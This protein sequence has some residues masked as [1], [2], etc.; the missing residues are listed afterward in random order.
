[1]IKVELSKSVSYVLLET[2]LQLMKDWCRKSFGPGVCRT[3]T[4]VKFVW[5]GGVSTNWD[6]NLNYVVEFSIIFYFK[7]EGYANLFLLKWGQE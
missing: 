1:M 2:R 7:S 5:R 4:P 6:I 3:E